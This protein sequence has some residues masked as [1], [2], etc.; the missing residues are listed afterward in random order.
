MIIIAS[1]IFMT[2]FGTDAL[3]V[4]SYLVLAQSYNV[5]IIILLVL[6]DFFFFSFNKRNLKVKSLVQG[7]TGSKWSQVRSVWLQNSFSSPLWILFQP[8]APF[9][10]YGEIN[11]TQ[12]L[13]L[14][15]PLE[16]QNNSIIKMMCKEGEYAQCFKFWTV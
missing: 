11:T 2:S 3:Q 6:Q 5:S 13:N 15:F 1:M 10:A 4:L 16:G 8:M 14:K 7:P 12:G 9:F